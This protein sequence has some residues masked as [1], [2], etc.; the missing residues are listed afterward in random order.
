MFSQLNEICSEESY[1]QPPCLAKSFFPQFEL[2]PRHWQ[3][4][5]GILGLVGGAVAQLL[6]QH[7]ISKSKNKRRI[8]SCKP[9]QA[10]RSK[11]K[12]KLKMVTEW[13]EPMKRKRLKLWGCW[14]TRSTA[15]VFWLSIPTKSLTKT[16]FSAF[17]FLSTFKCGYIFVSL[18]AEALFF[19]SI[20]WTFIRTTKYSGGRESCVN[21][22]KKKFRQLL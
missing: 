1:I 22:I 17:C 14:W 13:N 4:F 19:L 11:Y 21:V 5:P 9:E 7:S 8:W 10:D 16:K 18:K 15:S 12:T 20:F 2:F 3:V 6:K